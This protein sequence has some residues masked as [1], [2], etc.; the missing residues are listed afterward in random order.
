MRA[1]TAVFRVLGNR[2]CLSYLRNS[3]ADRITVL[4][5]H[6]VSPEHSP[7]WPPLKPEVFAGILE[8]LS[9]TYQCI[10][11]KAIGE[12]AGGKP[13]VIITFDDGYQDNFD[14]ALPLLEER[15]IK[16]VFSVVTDCIDKGEAIWTQKLNKI[17]EIY[18]D[19]KRPVEANG[20]YW[21]LTS[22]NMAVESTKIFLALL[23]EE[24]EE[25]DLK[26]AE[27]ERALPCKCEHTRMMTWSSVRH[28]AQRGHEIGSHTASHANLATEKNAEIVRR[29]LLSSK[30][31][32]EDNI[33]M[34]CDTI[35]YPN[36][37]YN[38]DVVKASRAV[39]Y[40]NLLLADE[41]LCQGGA[42]CSYK[43]VS[44]ITIQHES[45]AE[46]LLKVENFHNILKRHARRLAGMIRLAG[47]RK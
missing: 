21:H 3:K 33:G 31:A 1:R 42:A 37:Q 24:V 44:R 14:Y 10:L 12:E 32:I 26:I 40:K 4:C 39:G 20:M 25:R 16:A 27:L 23:T 6:R 43:V 2:F 28:L 29:E 15:N 18:L 5:F 9:A 47:Q 7:A 36:G 11:P 45:L 46:N 38:D 35:A 30:R 13:R 8:Y 41:E 22:K 17:L 19:L 34:A